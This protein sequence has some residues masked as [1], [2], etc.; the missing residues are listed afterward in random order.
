MNNQQKLLNQEPH[1]TWRILDELEAHVAILDSNGRI[2]KTNKAWRDFASRNPLWDG[3]LPA[4]CGIGANY[5]QVCRA[6]K[7]V[8]AENALLACQGI[9]DVLAGKKRTFS[10]EYPC[11]S[12]TQQRWFVMLVKP[13]R[14]STPRELVVVH[15]N[16]TPQKLAEF[17]LQ[18]KIA[19]LDANFKHLQAMM[20][21]TRNLIALE[22]STTPLA[23]PNR[24]GKAAA[25]QS[26]ASPTE[27]KLIDSLPKREK[28][29]LLALARG[30]RNTDIATTLK[31]STKSVST[32]RARVLDKLNAK[33]NADLVA[34][35]MRLQMR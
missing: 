13:L 19:D 18:Q 15:T 6:A 35:M 23:R 28:E 34:L 27:A 30:E 21:H 7:G 22:A 8:S 10:L 2:I 31:L 4:N 16:I 14:G 9:K 29:I 12:P 3:S 5:L 20:A 32:Y 11:H 33:T 25:T 1:K 26:K 24:L 17:A